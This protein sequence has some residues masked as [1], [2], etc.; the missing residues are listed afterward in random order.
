V[1]QP[2]VKPVVYGASGRLPR[3]D[4]SRGGHVAADFTCAQDYAAYTALE[5]NTCQRL[6]ERQSML[7]PGVFELNA[8]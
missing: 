8:N 2:A 5:R 4:Y 1:T 7:L 3:G 6:Y